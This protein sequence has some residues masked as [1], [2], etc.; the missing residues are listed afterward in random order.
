MFVIEPERFRIAS[1]LN[2]DTILF[3]DYGD[4][5]IGLLERAKA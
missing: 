1:P 2:Y 3:Q 5:I 4:T